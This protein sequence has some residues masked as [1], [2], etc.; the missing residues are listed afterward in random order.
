MNPLSILFT[1][2]AYFSR[3]NPDQKSTRS[4]ITLALLLILSTIAIELNSL[5]YFKIAVFYRLQDY[6][7]DF[8]YTGFYPAF[9]LAM[10][11]G[12]T[13]L[14][15]FVLDQHTRF[16]V[17]FLLPLLSVSLVGFFLPF[18]CFTM[19]TALL[20]CSILF[21]KILYSFF[22][23]T[24]HVPSRKAFAVALLAALPA[25]VMGIQRLWV[26]LCP[27]IRHHFFKF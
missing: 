12:M 17:G 13:R 4:W 27:I 26:I 2:T 21:A 24:L 8:I 19:G 3:L 9:I 7:V 20:L 18:N 16:D 11:Y 25:W 1:P 22:L 23:H 10:F 5:L 6:R 15:L 14:S